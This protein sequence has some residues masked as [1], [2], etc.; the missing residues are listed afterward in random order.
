MNRKAN[1]SSFNAKSYFLRDLKSCLKVRLLLS[2]VRIIA[3][4]AHLVAS[5]NVFR[6]IISRNR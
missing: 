3:I 6:R 2:S 1:E 4:N 5:G